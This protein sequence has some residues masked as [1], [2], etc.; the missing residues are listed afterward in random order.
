MKKIAAAVCAFLLLF[1]LS[2]CYLFE[3]EEPP[4]YAD[5]NTGISFSSVICG[6]Q[7]HFDL[8]FISDQSD[9]RVAYLNLSPSEFK[10]Y[11]IETGCYLFDNSDDISLTFF[12]KKFG[13][14]FS[15]NYAG[16]GTGGGSYHY[17]YTFNGTELTIDESIAPP[18]DGLSPIWFPVTPGRGTIIS[19]FNAAT[20]LSRTV[21]PYYDG[22][23][24][25]VY[26]SP[27]YYNRY[28]IGDTRECSFD[29]LQK[30]YS[31]VNDAQIDA[32]NRTITIPVYGKKINNEFIDGIVSDAYRA[33]I[34]T[35]GENL[36]KIEIE[37]I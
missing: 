2:G 13:S 15:V 11:L 3:Y 36:I 24:M 34:K 14:I 23:T 7:L 35:A 9:D 18:G 29:L 32:L 20:S 37:E 6:T 26:T 27:H 10:A 28:R 8:P 17:K 4:Y 25:T 21:N 12:Y 30:F 33:V 16:L 31:Y 1:S 22:E 19:P 5:I